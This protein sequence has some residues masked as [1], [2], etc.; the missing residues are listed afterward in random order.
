MRLADLALLGRHEI[1][2]DELLSTFWVEIA[3][4]A[5]YLRH[6]DPSALSFPSFGGGLGKDQ[7]RE[8]ALGEG[9]VGSEENRVDQLTGVVIPGR[10]DEWYSR[11]R[12]DDWDFVQAWPRRR[13]V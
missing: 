5:R 2:R 7:A 11:S 1:S 9:S 4:S 10:L 3:S 6:W 12:D 13:A 8:M